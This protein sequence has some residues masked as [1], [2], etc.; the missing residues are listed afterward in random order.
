MGNCHKCH[1]EGTDTNECPC[2]HERFCDDCQ[3]THGC[4]REECW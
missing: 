1:E 2:C 3:Y 4:K